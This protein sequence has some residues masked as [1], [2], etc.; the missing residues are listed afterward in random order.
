MMMKSYRTALR[1]LCLPAIFCAPAVHAQSTA[2]QDASTGAEEAESSGIGDIVVTARRRA[3]SLQ[4]VP[5]AVSALGAVAIEKAGITS[6]LDLARVT[7]NV[8]MT[9]FNVGE[10]Q[11]YIRGVGSQTDSAASEASVTVSVDDVAIGR[12]GAPAI[13]F[14]DVGRV[15]VL[16]GPQGTLYGRNASAGTISF[17]ANRPTD[18]FSGF[19]EG[20]YGSF[21]TYG[22]KAIVNA[23]LTDDVAIRAAGQYSD[24]DG[25]AKNVVTGKQLQGGERYSGRLQL[26]A[27]KEDWTFLVSAD[28][29]KDDLSGD[30]RYIISTPD[31]S[32]ALTAAANAAQASYAGDVWKSSGFPGTFQRRTNYG[33]TGRVEYDTGWSTVTSITAYRDNKYGLRADYGG[34]PAPFPLVVDDRIDEK[35]HQFSQELRL[36][37]VSSSKVQWVAGLFYYTDRVNRAEQFVNAALAPVPLALGGDNTSAQ[38]AKTTSYAAF[39]Q[40]T[41][42]FAR[43]F[44]LTLGGRISHDEKD[45]FQTLVHNGP[46]GQGVGFPFFPGTPYAVPASAKFT[47]PT[48]RATLAVEPWADKHFYI[49]YDRGYKAGTFTSQAQNATQATFVVKPEKLDSFNLG[50]KTQWLD[51]ALRLNADAFYLK[52]QDLQVFE[53]GQRLNFVLANADATVKGIE[54]QAVV[55]PTRFLTAGGN[56]SYQDAKFTSNPSFAGATLPYDGNRLS[57]APKVKYSLYSE[58]TVPVAEGTLLGRVSYEWQ[59]E[60][61][62]NPANEAASL[63]KSYGVLGGYLS[64]EGDNGLKFSLTGSNLTN[65]K[66]SV[67]SITLLGLGL[68]IYAPP[69]SVTFAVSKKF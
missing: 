38:S 56:F 22:V 32:A 11:T 37:S 42:P 41:I 19:V 54:L 8:T 3:E 61:F 26:Q 15:E 53:F 17:Y 27:Q 69:R 63:Q 36:N 50:M 20:S 58:F 14:L 46:A 31:A 60:F 30:S 57:K 51:N 43:I 55:A 52:Y 2:P 62:Y 34:V 12:G 29:S 5:L 49:S 67:H 6:V 45:V 21:N 68:R 18:G 47:K 48:W 1:T 23:P 7:P 64:W 39:G 4:D 9:Q 25:Y 59:D 16:R 10:P 35:S 24:S 13:A 65:T 33:L 28:Y 66:Y 44:E 40:A